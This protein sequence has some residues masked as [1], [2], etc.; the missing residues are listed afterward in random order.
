MEHA[1][2][3]PQDREKVQSPELAWR[4]GKLYFAFHAVDDA[5][6][7]CDDCAAEVAAVEDALQQ[8]TAIFESAWADRLYILIGEHAF[9]SSNC[10]Q[11]W[12]EI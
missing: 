7:H 9:R 2:D 5:L 11:Q 6:H 8:E 4:D 10:G 1:T 12:E 3:D